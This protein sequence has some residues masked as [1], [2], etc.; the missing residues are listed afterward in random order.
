MS[1]HY[2]ERMQTDLDEI[3]TKVHEVSDLVE[4]QVQH[5]IS[6]LMTYDRDI[7]A[8]VVLGD[9]QVNR[10]IKQIDYLCHNFIVRHA[11]SARP[12]RFASA[13]LRLDVAL[14]R[15][16][17]YADSIGREVARLSDSPPGSV[18]RDID[19]I[20]Q[21]ARHTLSQALIAFH[22][23]DVALARQ[24]YGLAEQ[25]DLTF[26][27][28]IDELHRAGE[29][30]KR[31][32]GDIFALLRIINL[33]KRVAEQSENICEQTVFAMTGEAKPPRIFRVLFVGERNDGA[34]QVAEAYARKAFPES[35]RY[36]SAG[37]DPAVSLDSALVEYLDGRGVDMRGAKPTPLT[38]VESAPEHYHVVVVFSPEARAHLGDVPYR[39][40]VVEWSLPT[41]PDG[42]LLGYAQL[43]EEIVVRV[44]DLMKT[45]AGPDA[46]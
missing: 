43:Y 24:T 10:R 17:D 26:E 39:T 14:E 33:I 38:D 36:A 12:L 13:V 31:P 5:A 23:G 16:G 29:K 42:A 44:Q 6:A 40:T 28:V 32:L 2:E 34:S 37:W 25:T 19:L 41:G 9:R 8:R 1:T 45:L 7:A 11:P 27:T 4:S 21:Q 30:G 18:G 3:R 22:T 35:G 46:L 20:A 15:I